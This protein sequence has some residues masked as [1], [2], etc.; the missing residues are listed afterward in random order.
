MYQLLSYLAYLTISSFIT[1]YVGWKCYTYGFVYLSYLMKDTGL[2][3]AINNMLLCGYYLL[4][5]GYIAWSLN[6]WQQVSGMAE[7]LSM[8]SYKVGV[9][10]LILCILHYINMTVIYILSKKNILHV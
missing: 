9:I 6:S 7:T 8:V 2:C 3:K 1:I 10:T 5:I 4:N